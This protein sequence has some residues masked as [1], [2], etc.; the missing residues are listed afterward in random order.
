MGHSPIIYILPANW[1]STSDKVL[2]EAIEEDKDYH[3][4]PLGYF[5]DWDIGIIQPKFL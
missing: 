2:N 4:Y 1:D 3:I 5:V